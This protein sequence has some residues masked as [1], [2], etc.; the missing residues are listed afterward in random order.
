M[1]LY[2]VGEEEDEEKIAVAFDNMQ[3]DID[4]EPD[5][6]TLDQPPVHPVAL[7]QG[8]FEESIFESTDQN[9]GQDTD[10]KQD[11]AD[12]TVWRQKLLD[13]NEQPNGSTSRWKQRPN[14]KFH[15]LWKLVAQITFGMH[16]LHQQLAKS[17][18]EVVKILQTHVDEI[19]SFLERANDDFDLAI[20]DIDER[21]RYLKLPLEHIDVFDVMLEDKQFRTSIIDGNDKIEKIVKQ[22][23]RGMH[24]ALFDISR[25]LEA[26]AEL[27]KYLESLGIEWTDGNDELRSTYDVMRANVEGWLRAFNDLQMKG[28]S[29]NLS[30]VKLGSIIGEMSKRAGIASR[31]HAQITSP[32]RSPRLNPSRI[33][34]PPPASRYAGRTP[35]KPLPHEPDLIK[36]AVE[37]TLP[38][39]TYRP[40][41]RWE[42]PREIPQPPMRSEISHSRTATPVQITDQRK[43][44]ELAQRFNSKRPVQQPPSE[45]P[46]ISIEEKPSKKKTINA[47][48]RRLSTQ[49][50]LEKQ[51]LKESPTTI[52]SAYSSGSDNQ[53]EPSIK[54]P[55]LGSPRI[56]SPRP[57]TPLGLFP[58]TS[59]PLTPSVA[60]IRS[61]SVVSRL[62]DDSAAPAPVVDRQRNP[63]LLRK[64][65]SLGSVKEFFQR[66][67]RNRRNS[68][69]LTSLQP[70]DESQVVH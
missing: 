11:K 46:A 56:A 14:A 27:K 64:K 5:I 43:K 26:T 47:L 29:L 44:F 24:D 37:A 2:S 12:P 18:E 9:V 19:D 68:S 33:R 25:G 35:K 53:R 58:N 41:R 31:R 13:G 63:G 49:K 59:R 48:G 39:S 4:D 54:S 7:M 55:E 1:A 70:L 32:P 34:S 3:L 10:A 16:L 51:D 52:D 20:K 57:A 65:S 15:P 42:Q 67:R 61:G 40:E 38:H 30:M 45:L 69:T 50:K 28:H 8:A 22:T 17:D 21:I 23:A 60:S 6:I 36:P 66:Q 62:G